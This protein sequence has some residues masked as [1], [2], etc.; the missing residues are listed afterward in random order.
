M[1]NIKTN[2]VHKPDSNYCVALFED[3]ISI[4]VPQVVRANT[5]FD[6]SK[7]EKCYLKSLYFSLFK[8]NSENISK[9]YFKYLLTAQS[10]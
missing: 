8:E 4:N 2:T 7:W 10:V 6:E 9:Y 5:Q 3:I 1:F